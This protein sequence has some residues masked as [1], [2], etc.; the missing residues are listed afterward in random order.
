M[1]QRHERAGPCRI[2]VPA[3]GLDEDPRIESLVREIRAGADAFVFL[4][5][6]ASGMADEDRRQL[7][8]LF[9]AFSILS[10]GGLR[11]AVGD[12]GT[13]AGIMQAAGEARLASG[14][15][16]PL[17]GVAPAREIPPRGETPIEPNHSHVVAID[18]PDWVGA[19][20]WGSET[21][22]MYRI[23]ARLAAGRP[24][25]TVVANGGAIAL[26]EVHRNLE[27]RRPMIL[28]AGSGRA[29]DALVAVLRETP[30]GDPQMAELAAQVRQRGLAS[31]PA[32]FTVFELSRGPAAL[33]DVLRTAMTRRV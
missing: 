4:S 9:D 6:G 15:K 27:A 23:F 25:V 30:A 28:V 18:D 12:G 13:Q 1:S 29:A 32:L 8:A 17:I 19:D 11:F 2:D 26:S 7:L 20:A 33:A 10:R 21:D 31:S 3:A 16:F 5:G 14:E 22:G 24:S